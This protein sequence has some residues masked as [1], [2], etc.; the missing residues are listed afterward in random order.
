MTNRKAIHLIFGIGL[1]CLSV[2]NNFQHKKKDKEIILQRFNTSDCSEIL[3]PNRLNTRIVSLT[4]T[5][6]TTFIE[7]SFS[8]D[9]C[10]DPQPKIS[11]QNSTLSIELNSKNQKVIC[12]CKCC[13]NMEL[14][15][16]G[17]K[18]SNFRTTF[19]KEEI[20]LS[21]LYYKDTFPEVYEII[22]GDTVNRKNIYGHKT[23][24]WYEYFENSKVV[25]SKIVYSGITGNAKIDI[26][27]KEVYY[28]NG[29]L[30]QRIIAD[31]SLDYYNRPGRKDQLDR[32]NFGFISESFFE[33]GNIQKRCIPTWSS[34]SSKYIDS[35][36][37][38]N[39][40]GVPVE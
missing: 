26:Q 31:S 4:Q 34:D 16:T 38:W 20:F 22:N 23:Q 10:L 17:I 35:C 25:K 5:L 15:V 18:E 9:C 27:S 39:E 40:F 11:F 1:I 28:L 12:E 19:N 36:I 2:G 21:D 8:E 37:Y 6:D 7:I 14:V 33:N 3:D 30:N 32:L 13:Y 29:N 24:D